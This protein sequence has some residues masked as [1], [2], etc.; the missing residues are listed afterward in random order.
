MNVARGNDRNVQLIAKPDNVSVEITQFFLAL[1]GSF[2]QHEP[3]V[4]DR[5]NFQIVVIA[6]DLLQLVPRGPAHHGAEQLARLASGTD[7]QSLA[8]LV[9]FCFWDPRT[10]IKIIEMRLGNQFIKVFQPNLVLD[11]NNLMIGRNFF[12]IAA[13][14]RCV[15]LRNLFGAG[16]LLDALNQQKKNIR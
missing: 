7:N 4:A 10:L 11:E 8:Q 3:V 14:Q 13:G 16:V 9:E 1:D 15:Q 2:A 6:R 12:W 5:L